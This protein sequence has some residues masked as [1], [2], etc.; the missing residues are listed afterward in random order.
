MDAFLFFFRHTSIDVWSTAGILHPHTT[1]CTFDIY[2][3]NPDVESC[4]GR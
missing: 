4:N 2:L 1:Y 3:R